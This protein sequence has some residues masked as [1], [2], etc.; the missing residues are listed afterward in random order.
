MVLVFNNKQYG[1]VQMMQ[2][3]DHGGRVIATDLHNPDFVALA[4]SFGA[5]GATITDAAGRDL[6]TVVE[7][8][9][10]DMPSM[11]RFR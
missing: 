3:D 10:G 11:D 4:E 2:K 5:V 7:I 8:T 1:N 6:P 9:V